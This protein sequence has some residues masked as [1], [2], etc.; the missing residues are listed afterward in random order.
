MVILVNI[1]LWIIVLVLYRD[2]CGVCMYL[3]LSL[4]NMMIVNM[5]MHL[6]EIVIIVQDLNKDCGLQFSIV[7][8]ASNNRWV[9]SNN[10]G[11]CS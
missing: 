6:N 9:V 8:M 7:A 4:C 5:R 1:F 10:R 2:H 3:M 11:Y